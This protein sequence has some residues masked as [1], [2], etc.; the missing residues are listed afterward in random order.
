[1]KYITVL[2]N[3][4]TLIWNATIWGESTLWSALA[5]RFP[6]TGIFVSS[7]KVGVAFRS[8]M[9]SWLFVVSLWIC[10]SSK[11]ASK[12]KQRPKLSQVSSSTAHST[13]SHLWCQSRHQIDSGK[14]LT[15]NHDARASSGRVC[16]DVTTPWKRSHYV[17]CWIKTLN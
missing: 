7:L 15:C 12:Y 2:C 5:S 8:E 14:N 13:H 3:A 10:I 17:F 16:C 9:S 6:Q 11:L 4:L 1:M